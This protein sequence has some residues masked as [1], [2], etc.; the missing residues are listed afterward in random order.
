[1]R[2]DANPEFAKHFYRALSVV[3]DDLFFARYRRE[4]SPVTALSK[5]NNG[6]MESAAGALLKALYGE[7]TTEEQKHVMMEDLLDTRVLPATDGRGV[8]FEAD[9]IK[10]R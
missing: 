8:Q 1:M 5:S 4:S 9:R 10:D 3:C 2:D 7:A 6:S